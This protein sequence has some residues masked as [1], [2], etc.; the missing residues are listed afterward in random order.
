MYIYIYIF[1]GPYLF[2]TKVQCKILIK[3]FAKPAARR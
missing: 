1:E 3:M 2:F